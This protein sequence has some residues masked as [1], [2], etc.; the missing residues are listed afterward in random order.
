LDPI[1]EIDGWRID[2]ATMR[3]IDM[4]LKRRIPEPLSPEFLAP[5][6]APSAVQT[7]AAE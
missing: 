3:E 1:N 5:P 7:A 6:Q 4:I 2:A